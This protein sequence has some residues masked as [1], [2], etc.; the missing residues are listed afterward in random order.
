MC[1]NSRKA[2]QVKQKELWPKSLETD[3][4]VGS[5]HDLLFKH[6]LLYL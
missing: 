5:A 3:L 4:T 1:F 6:K 2:E